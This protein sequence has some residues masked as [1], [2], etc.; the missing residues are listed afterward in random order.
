MTIENE[1]TKLSLMPR[2]GDPFHAGW[3]ARLLG[4]PKDESNGQTWCEGW[5]IADE[6]GET[7]WLACGDMIRLGQLVVKEGES[8]P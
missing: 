3:W 4:M 1:W 5:R 7:A 2:D 8:K 6:T